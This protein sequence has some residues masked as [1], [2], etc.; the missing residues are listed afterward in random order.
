MRRRRALDTE[1]ER[2]LAEAVLDALVD[3]VAVVDFD[4]DIVWVNKAWRSCFGSSRDTVGEWYGVEYLGA[5]AAPKFMDP[6]DVIATGEGLRAVLAGEQLDF[7]LEYRSHDADEPR[8]LS[9]RAQRANW[10]GA[11][12][13]VV[14]HTDITDRRLAEEWAKQQAIVDSVTGVANR[15]R[16][17]EFLFAEWRRARREHGAVSLVLLDIDRFKA[18]NDRYGHQAGDVVLRKVAAAIRRVARRPGDLIAR[19]GGEEFGMILGSTDADAA[20]QLAG[21]AIRAVAE[22]DI[23]H[24]DS[25]HGDRLTISAGVSG[26]PCGSTTQP[27]EAIAALV[28]AADRALYAAKHAGG[29]C[30]ERREIGETVAGPVSG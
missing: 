26:G 29:N 3:L 21:R 14:T 16:F 2:D 23:T 10:A 5:T 8:W 6:V 27:D 7:T 4:G 28:N 19:Y 17:D 11:A 18:Y 24:D 9:V 25:A 22:L 30:V 12:R 1:L 13:V 20:E 15:R